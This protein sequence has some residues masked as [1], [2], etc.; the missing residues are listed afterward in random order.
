MAD[1]SNKIKIALTGDKT[2]EAIDLYQLGVILTN[3]QNIYDKGYCYYSGNKKMTAKIRENFKITSKSFKRGSIIF[4]AEVFICT[5]QQILGENF[6]PELIIKTVSE[7]FKYLCAILGEKQKGNTPTINLVNSPGA[8]CIVNPEKNIITVSGNAVK[9]ADGIKRPLKNI[10]ESV[11]ENPGTELS[12]VPKNNEITP[13]SITSENAPLFLQGYFRSDRRLY[14][15]GIVKN[16]SADSFSGQIQILPSAHLPIAPEKYS[17]SILEEY[18]KRDNEAFIDS[19]KGH[20][21]NVD[22]YAEYEV[23]GKGNV[24]DKIRKLYLSLHNDDN[25]E[26]LD[27]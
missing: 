24:N 12:I 27:F 22:A 14:L 26:P 1:E 16:Y 7:A 6:T 17:F 10:A 9:L 25:Y 20:P 11:S 5:A 21:I 13:V 23:Y 15:R 3:V 8:I 2:K 4:D 19:L 18:R